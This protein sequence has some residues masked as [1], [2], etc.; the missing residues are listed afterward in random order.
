[1]EANI[2]TLLGNGFNIGLRNFLRDSFVEIEI[3]ENLNK[4]INLWNSFDKVLRDIKTR[5]P[6]IRT[7]E[8]A[9]EYI[10]TILD[11]F[12]LKSRLK[13]MPQLKQCLEQLENKLDNEIISSINEISFLFFQLEKGLNFYRK[14]VKIL[15]EHLANSLKEFNN[16][17][18]IFTTNYDGIA[19]I[20]HYSF[21]K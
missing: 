3:L 17:G 7:D 2:I 1:M 6:T 21:A 15:K 13:D 4:I 12:K 9:L 19:E 14:L 8:E 10:Y 11:F 20:F 18:D 16:L 5:I